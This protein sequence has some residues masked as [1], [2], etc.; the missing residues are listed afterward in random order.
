MGGGPPPPRPPPRPRFPQSAQRQ[1]LSRG[2]LLG[3]RRTPLAIGGSGVR[4]VRG[5]SARKCPRPGRYRSAADLGGTKAQGEG[6]EAQGEA[7]GLVEAE[8][9]VRSIP[10][11]I[12]VWKPMCGSQNQVARPNPHGVLP[13][14]MRWKWG[15]RCG[16]P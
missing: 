4:E 16:V 2:A 12:C 7:M 1:L 10:D 9:E 8:E 14:A 3:M 6:T 5:E 11:P 15:S 13:Q